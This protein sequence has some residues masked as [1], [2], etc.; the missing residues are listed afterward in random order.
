MGKGRTNFH[1][2]QPLLP[3]RKSSMLST[4]RACSCSGSGLSEGELFLRSLSVS[5]S[6]SLLCVSPHHVSLPYSKGSCPPG[7]HPAVKQSFPQEQLCVNIAAAVGRRHDRTW[8]N[9]KQLVRR[10]RNPPFPPAPPAPGG[11][12]EKRDPEQRVL[13]V[14]PS[15]GSCPGPGGCQC[16][17]DL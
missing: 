8:E 2:G 1:V 3:S 6:L 16:Q 12:E 10:R 5:L 15:P 7:K 9:P 4:L 11:R 17:I 13:E 14:P